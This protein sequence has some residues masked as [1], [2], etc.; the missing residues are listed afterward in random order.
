VLE[1]LK[2]CKAAVAQG[3]GRRIHDDL[4]A[5]GIE[6]YIVDETDPDAARELGMHRSNLHRLAVRLGLRNSRGAPSVR[7]SRRQ[8]D[9]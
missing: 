8:R 2:G 3:M 6:A 1:A 7:R 4:R 9:S 5:A